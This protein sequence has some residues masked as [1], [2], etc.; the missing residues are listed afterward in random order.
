M[1]VHVEPESKPLQCGGCG[2]GFFNRSHLADHMGKCGKVVLSDEA[3]TE[4]CGNE[5]RNCGN[6]ISAGIVIPKSPTESSSPSTC[7]MKGLKMVTAVEPSY[8][9]KDGLDSQ[10]GTYKQS[11]VVSQFK[12]VACLKTYHCYRDLVSHL[13]A[14]Q[15]MSGYLSDDGR[16]SGNNTTSSTGSE[17]PQCHLVF[18]RKD[19]LESHLKG[20]SAGSDNKYRCS[21]CGWSILRLNLI[22][23]HV[24]KCPL[25][26]KKWK[27]SPPASSS[28]CPICLSA[29]VSSKSLKQHILNCH[30]GL[31]KDPSSSRC[32][33]CFGS[34]GS[35]GALTLHQE[36][37]RAYA[38]RLES[39]D[40]DSTCG[41]CLVQTSA[42]D[43]H[44]TRYHIIKD[45]SSIRCGI[46]GDMFS[47]ISELIS[48]SS[49]CLM[50]RAMLQNQSPF[51]K[52]RS[53]T[54]DMSPNSQKTMGND[55][56]TN[57]MWEELSCSSTST[58]NGSEKTG[59]TLCG[60]VFSRAHM[61]RHLYCHSE[62]AAKVRQHQCL[63]CNGHFISVFHL[64][65]HMKACKQFEA[66]SPM[67]TKES[68]VNGLV[69]LSDQTRPSMKVNMSE[70]S[71]MPR[72]IELSESEISTDILSCQR[73]MQEFS[74]SQKFI[75]HKAICQAK[76][77][78]VSDDYDDDDD[79][80][81]PA[82]VEGHGDKS[83]DSNVQVR[84]IIILVIKSEVVHGSPNKSH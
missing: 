48:H 21:G 72:D 82:A 62:E 5:Y 10:T 35:E 30:V 45:T 44:F 50:L 77:Q 57:D 80:A 3:D 76:S 69:C 12:C 73:C 64:Q 61:Q 70:L 6:G 42:I 34:F 23:E 27:S 68:T 1:T 49:S 14:C 22:I 78:S 52:L 55:T 26:I 32:D 40:P 43:A 16:D 15:S 24:K 53:K 18:A 79:R 38:R 51:D 60:I 56:S 33:G 31:Y 41:V 8:S 58:K 13:P 74:S 84:T 71:E 28:S 65:R 39:A 59:C 9:T 47:S 83:D 4:K 20:H 11:H 25:F 81:K 67:E 75:T 63:R 36:R 66:A 19:K 2:A 54:L 46:C 29:F 7:A 17:C 37:C